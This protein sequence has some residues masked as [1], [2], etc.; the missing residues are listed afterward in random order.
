MNGFYDELAPYYHLIFQDWRAAV[1]RQGARLDSV[2][3]DEWGDGV[4]SVLD[5]SC[6]IGTQAI[7]LAG[8]GF[9]VT[10]SDLSEK[11][12]DRAR[13]EADALGLSIPFSVC[14]MR[15]VR[16]HHGARFDLVISCDNSIPHLLGDEEILIAL[17]EFHACARPGGGCLLTVRDYETEERGRGLVKPYGIREDGDRRYLLFQVWD[18]EGDQYDV[19]FY[20]VEDG[21]QAGIV[22]THVMRSRYYAIPCGR[23]LELMEEAGFHS[24]R[25]VPGDFPQPTLVGTKAS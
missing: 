25:R 14:D 16:S 6:G 3:A 21:G 17:R 10:A 2:I 4:R 22:T 18:F 1:E 5:V 11:S 12:I 15:H 8:R 13:E 19:S 20:I 9:D 23:L 24:V 7:G